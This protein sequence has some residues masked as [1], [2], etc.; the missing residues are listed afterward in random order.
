MQLCQHIFLSGERLELDVIKRHHFKHGL[1]L[2]VAE[3]WIPHSP[4]S[5]LILEFCKASPRT[6]GALVHVLG[7][8]VEVICQAQHMCCKIHIILE[9]P[10]DIQCLLYCFRFLQQNRTC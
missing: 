2:E 7:L 9:T 3:D 4:H 6:H 5:S 1:H 10:Q 8:S